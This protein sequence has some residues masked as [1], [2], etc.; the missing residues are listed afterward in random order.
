[1]TIDQITVQVLPVTYDEKRLIAYEFPPL[2]LGCRK[3]VVENKG[4]LVILL[5]LPMV[6]FYIVITFQRFAIVKQY[7]FRLSNP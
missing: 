5:F 1:M 6:S 7:Y 3:R 4:F 2:D